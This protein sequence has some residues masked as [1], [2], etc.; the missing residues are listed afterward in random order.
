MNWKQ[1]I[2]YSIYIVSNLLFLSTPLQNYQSKLWFTKV[3]LVFLISTSIILSMN[4]KHNINNNYLFGGLLYLNIFILIPLVLQSIKRPILNNISLIQIITIL[5]IISLLVTFKKKDFE[6]TD[7][8]LKNPNK[9]W[10]L[11]YVFTVSLWCM[12]IYYTNITPSFRLISILL[13][14]LPLLFS[15]KN[16][17][18]IR[19]ALLTLA[20]GIKYK[21][22]Y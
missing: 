11:A 7:G 3:L 13:V 8:T 10:I 1:V 18:I 20:I 21:Y 15:L 22:F 2:Y 6:L 9:N 14:S 16:Y 5:S 17:Y 19:V 4:R 12:G